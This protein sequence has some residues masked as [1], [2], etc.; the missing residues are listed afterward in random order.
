MRIVSLK[1]TGLELTDAIK[2]YV[3]EKVES[4]LKLCESFDPADE[5]R[6]EVG[7]TTKHHAKGPYFFAEMQLHVPGQDLRAVEE[8][9]DLHEAIDLAK[10][11]LKRQLKEYKDRLVDRTQKGAR[12]GKE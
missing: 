10:D 12:P 7:K 8:A 9:E 1:G 11:H 3:D 5:L 6:I 2:T 4:L